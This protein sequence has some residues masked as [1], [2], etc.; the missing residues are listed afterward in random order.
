MIGDMT[1]GGPD[2]KGEDKPTDVQPEDDSGP[3]PFDGISDD[4]LPDSW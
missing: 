1:A 4:D 3:S 2:T